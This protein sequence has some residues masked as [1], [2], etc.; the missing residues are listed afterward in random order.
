MKLKAICGKALL[1][2]TLLP[3]SAEGALYKYADRGVECYTD[4]LGKI[5]PKLRKK[6]VDVERGA[7]SVVITDSPASGTDTATREQEK[8]QAMSLEELTKAAESGNM[9]AQN[10][11]GKRYFFGDG[12][13]ASGE[14]A[15]YWYT[16]SA[17]SG[18]V[19]AQAN[20]AGMLMTGRGGFMDIGEGMKWLKSAADQGDATSQYN[21]GREYD[22]G[23]KVKNNYAEAARYYQKAVD[24]GFLEAHVNLAILYERGFGVEK[25]VDKARE[26]Y[27]FAADAGVP[28]AIHNLKGMRLRNRR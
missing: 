1:L 26:L 25:N 4:D 5:P 7:A 14:K 13:P 28:Q 9:Y 23:Y 11:L 24:Q 19:F 22:T 12:V 27:Q 6:A 20:L 2:I 10:V 8:Y 16:R 3:F 21:L 15:R 18:Y 17:K